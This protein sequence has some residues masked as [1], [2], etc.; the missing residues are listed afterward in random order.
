MKNKPLIIIT[1]PT[2]S[3]KSR[4]SVMLSHRIGG[5][6]IS[7]DSM[8]IYRGMDIGT[9]KVTAEEMDGIPHYLIDIMDPEESYDVTRFK[10]E[11][12]K[13]IADIYEKG[14]IPIVC[15]GTGFYIQALLYDVEFD[16][17]GADPDIRKRLEEEYES[18][19]PD[20]LFER[21]RSVD[22]ASCEIIHHNNKKRLVRALEFYETTGSPISDHNKTE[23]SRHS[24]YDHAFF[25]LNIDRQLLYD[26]IDARVDQMMEV[27]LLEEARQLYDRGLPRENTAMQAIGY[28]QLFMY[29][30]GDI[31]LEEGIRLIKRDSRHYAKRQFTWLRRE[32]DVIWLDRE[33]N[34][35]EILGDISK[36]LKERKI[37]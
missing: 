29:F 34:D 33:K 4:L 2:G 6:V 3:G 5:S 19:G 21:L 24:A 30:D 12:Q 22:L 23:R 17:E 14:R 1:G 16:D 31:S 32:R 8:Q 28:K 7:A 11:A 20:I 13:A 25:A 18:L 9:A 27:G 35:E 10:T 37:L 26:R 36:E 15:G